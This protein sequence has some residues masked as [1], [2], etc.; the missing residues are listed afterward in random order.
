MGLV[1]KVYSLASVTLKR[2]IITADGVSRIQQDAME[3]PPLTVGPMIAF[4]YKYLLS[5]NSSVMAGFN[6][7]ATTSFEH[8]PTHNLHRNSNLNVFVAYGF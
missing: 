8:R 3:L 1:S 6:A 5:A 7:N 2:E 4:G